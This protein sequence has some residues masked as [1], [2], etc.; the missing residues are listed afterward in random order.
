MTEYIVRESGYPGTI[1]KEI[2][3]EIVRCKDCRYNYDGNCDAICHILEGDLIGVT[4][5]CY[6][7][8]F[9]AYGE[10]R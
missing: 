10:R 2:V 7:D 9:C 8:F 1:K 5:R 3:G 4:L 6:D